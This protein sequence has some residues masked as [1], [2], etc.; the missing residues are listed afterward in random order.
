MNEQSILEEFEEADPEQ[1]FKLLMAHFGRTIYYSQ[2]LEQQSINMLA[3]KELSGISDFTSAKVDEIFDKYDFSKQTLGTFSKTIAKSFNLSTEDVMELEAV[4]KLR[5]H[6]T[7]SYFR[8]NDVLMH[9]D[10]GKIKMI[11]DFNAFTIRVKSIDAKLVVYS[12]RYDQMYGLTAEV[13]QAQMD[14]VRDNWKDKE[15]G[16]DYDSIKKNN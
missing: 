14:Q 4:I 6:F 7:H 15:I 1:Q 5:N 8:F 13:Y 10:S 16:D 2:L 11:K 3:V 12:D 9:S